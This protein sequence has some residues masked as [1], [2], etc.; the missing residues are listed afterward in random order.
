MLKATL[1]LGSVTYV[2]GTLLFASAL[3]ASVEASLALWTGFFSSIAYLF[4]V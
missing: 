4:E 1:I 3:M 2:L